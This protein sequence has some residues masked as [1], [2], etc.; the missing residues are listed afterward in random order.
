MVK[1]ELALLLVG[2]VLVL[3]VNGKI[4][5]NAVWQLLMVVAYGVGAMLWLTLR[6]RRILRQQITASQEAGGIDGEKE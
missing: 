3:L 1:L 4:T 5:D 2:A 6:T